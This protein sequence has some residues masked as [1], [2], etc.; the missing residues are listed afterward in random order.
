MGYATSRKFAKART[1]TDAFSPTVFR[2]A[3]VTGASRGIGAAVARALAAD[4]HR[5]VMNYLGNHEAAEQVA[6]EIRAKGGQVELCPFDVGDSNQSSEALAR[7][8]VNRDPFTIVI[9]NAGVARDNPFAGMKREQWE[10]VMRTS[11]DGFF[12]VTQP[13]TLPMMRQRFGR[14]VNLVSFSGV[15]GNRG[16][17]NYGAA[18]AGLIG[19]TK[20]LAKELASRNITVNAVCPGLIDTEMLSSVDTD[21]YLA[22]V[23]MG[24]MGQPEEVA[25]AIRYLVSEQSSYVTGVVLEVGGGFKG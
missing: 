3:L 2:R 5:V 7:L 24:R 21:A 11:L 12:N 14:I 25:Q 1:M 23:P 22:S 9:N 8:E 4:G 20:S 17:V 6:S 16:Q 19:A 10:R 18:K 15:S 13:L